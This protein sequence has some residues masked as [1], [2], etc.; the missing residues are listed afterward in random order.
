MLTRRSS[1]LARAQLIRNTFA[2]IKGVEWHR[3][4]RL[5]VNANFKWAIFT[6]LSVCFAKMVGFELALDQGAVR[7][8]ECKTSSSS[9]K[10]RVNRSLC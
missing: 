4:A 7:H 6:Q 3:T 10:N 5:R 9:L 1:R 2:E 8:T